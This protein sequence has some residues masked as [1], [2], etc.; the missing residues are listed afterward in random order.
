MS[1]SNSGPS[2]FAI[3]MHT[4]ATIITG[5]FWLVPL[6]IYYVSSKVHGKRPSLLSVAANTFMVLITGGFWLI[7]LGIYYLTRK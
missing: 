7:P 6:G 1:K 5:G 3:L 4:L 2:F